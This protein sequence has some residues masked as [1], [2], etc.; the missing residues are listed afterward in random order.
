MFQLSICLQTCVH[1]SLLFVPTL[2]TFTFITFW[3]YVPVVLKLHPTCSRMKSRSFWNH[4]LHVPEKVHLSIRFICG[5]EN[6]RRIDS[7]PHIPFVLFGFIWPTSAGLSNCI[8][9]ICPRFRRGREG[10]GGRH[11]ISKSIPSDRDA[12]EVSALFT[13]L[14]RILFDLLPLQDTP[15]WKSGRT[16][17]DVWFYCA[18]PCQTPPENE[19]CCVPVHIGRV[20]IPYQD[21]EK[22]I[23]WIA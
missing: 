11:R 12:P 8:F 21:S 20:G 23:F 5:W 22:Y 4:F 3:N 13:L 10:D 7:W 16:A 19:R 2:S 14:L 9:V 6:M 15:P 18:I 17:G 1:T